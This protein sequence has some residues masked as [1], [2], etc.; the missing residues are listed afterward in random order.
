M[1]ARTLRAVLG[2][3]RHLGTRPA[4]DA[5]SLPRPRGRLELVRDRRGVPHVYAEDETDLFTAL[6]YLQAADRFVLLDLV[7]HL[8]AGRLT[9]L[10]GN[11]R[12][13]ADNELFG[14]RNLLDLDAF[15]R[16]LDFE[17]DAEGAVERLSDRGRA[18]LTA[19]SDGV[20]AA[21]RAMRGVYPTEYLGLARPRPWRPSDCLL[22][23]RTSGFVVS[24]MNFEN[25]LSF[26]AVRARVGD[27]L[28]RRIYPD[29]PWHA[30]PSS[31]RAE[32]RVPP[33]APMHLPAAG[34]NNWAVAGWR[35]ASGA[36]IV[37][38]D[39][40]VPIVPLPTYWYHAHLECPEYRVQG[41]VFPGC[42]I[43]G[44]GHNGHL[45]WGCTTGFRD[46]WDFYRIHRLPDDATRYRSVE[47]SARIQRHRETHRVRWGR[48]A[49]LEWE[50][51]DH[52]VLYPDWKHHDG[53]DLA[54]RYVPADLARYLEGYL[55][56]SAAS[57]VEQHRA[58]L[59]EINEGPFDFNH[60][61]AHRD[62]HLGWELFGRLPSRRG[63]GLFV[64]D[65][66]DPEAQWD[67]FVP[68]EEMPKILNPDAGYVASANSSVDPDDHARIASQVHFEPRYRQDRIESVLAASREH[69]CD[70]FAA[71]QSDVFAWY[72]PPLRDAWLSLL[73]G[74]T[75]EDSERGRSLRE[76]AGWSGD[77]V[78]DSA[79][80]ASFFFAQ[81][82]L[83][84][85]CFEALL[86][87]EVGRRFGNGRRALPRLQRMLLATDDPLRLDVERACGLSLSALATEAFEAG[88]G[89][90]RAICGP[91]PERWRWGA[92]Q[93]ARLG[94]LL[95]E[96]PRVGKRFLALDA[97]FPGDDYTVSP[98][99]ALDEGHR[100][101]A[102]I[103]ASSRFIC[104][105]G[106]P[107]EALFAHSS[108]PSG[109][110]GSAFFANLSG[111]WQRFEYFRSALWAPDDVPDAV[112]RCVL[113]PV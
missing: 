62:G 77:F 4:F 79:A 29:A 55:A 11:P 53:T 56:L 66:H 33:E 60:V 102:F 85:R 95:A 16:P 97:P 21:L 92:I 2:S 6:G 8:G 23:Q 17:A 12:A 61:Y 65:A 43:F 28:A 93:R 107:D 112:E 49:T 14:G 47:G 104:D 35:S 94:T 18:S 32:G 40:H 71:L 52:G 82:E 37:A 108:G 67:G 99:R 101:R 78:T 15:V 80:A 39:P 41:G 51:C 27:E 5:A 111:P 9:E 110:V 89:R 72:A 26:D 50:S 96:L 31:Y 7:R 100:L 24:L 106:R 70:S 103:G 87:P 19:F 90:I 88:L 81:K 68:F 98:S 74:I 30:A 59:A 113:E 86:G 22:V 3:R 69:T 105:L 109:D 45:A 57:T 13:P 25:E 64:R 34:S 58:A 46:G 36:P 10:I 76:L 48:D 73:S 54:V 38:N 20:N 91:D 42:P 75:D 84:R 44:F 63:D 83:S 1:F